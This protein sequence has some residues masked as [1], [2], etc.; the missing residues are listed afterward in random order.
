MAGWL[1]YLGLSQPQAEFIGN[2]LIVVPVSALGSMLWARTTW[3]TWTAIAFTGACLVE[4]SQGLLLPERTASGI[5]VVANTL[6]GLIGALV[7]LG[8]RR[9]RQPPG[10]AV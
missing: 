7:A 10:R 2:I 4:L 9:W 1:T 3:L 6:G 8:A 5:D